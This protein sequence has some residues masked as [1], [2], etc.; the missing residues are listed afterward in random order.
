MEKSVKRKKENSQK[1]KEEIRGKI[2]KGKGKKHTKRTE[3]EVESV[4]K[5]RKEN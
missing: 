2:E 5:R 4:I 3:E 1:M